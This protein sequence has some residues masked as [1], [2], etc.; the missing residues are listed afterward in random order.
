MYCS[1]IDVIQGQLFT[2]S[3]E[4]SYFNTRGENVNEIVVG[5]KRDCSPYKLIIKSVSSKVNSRRFFTHCY[6]N[7]S[8]TLKNN[9]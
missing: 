6:N 3:E 9:S 8:V 4:E 7:S 1:L 2:Q 5:F